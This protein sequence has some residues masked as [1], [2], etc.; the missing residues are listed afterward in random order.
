V[1]WGCHDDAVFVLETPLVKTLMTQHLYHRVIHSQGRWLLR[2]S[3]PTRTIAVICFEYLHDVYGKFRMLGGHMILYEHR[4]M[5]WIV[6]AKVDRQTTCFQDESELRWIKGVMPNR[7]GE[8]RI[9]TLFSN[10]VSCMRVIRERQMTHILS[11]RHPH[12]SPNS[13]RL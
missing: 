3:C 10:K 8:G 9:K 13:V 11:L 6:G 2:A 7:L 1:G 5:R 4:T 12:L